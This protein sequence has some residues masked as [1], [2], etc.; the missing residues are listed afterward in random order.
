MDWEPSPSLRRRPLAVSQQDD[1]D[2]DEITPPRKSDWDAFATNRQRM[3]PQ[4]VEE[5]GLESLLAGWG[6]RERE[7]RETKQGRQKGWFW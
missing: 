7:I 2:A 5:T 1:E 4:K 3:Y 6:I